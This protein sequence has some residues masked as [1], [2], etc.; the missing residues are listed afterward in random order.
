M[1]G[2]ICLHILCPIRSII[3][4]RNEKKEISDGEGEPRGAVFNALDAMLKGTLDRLK[5]MRFVFLSLIVW[6]YILGYCANFSYN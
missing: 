2:Q 1:N 3:S 5:T 6:V 4:D